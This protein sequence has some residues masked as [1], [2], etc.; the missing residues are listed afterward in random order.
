MPAT[1]TV[2]RLT[3]DDA[4]QVRE[5]AAA[6]RAHDGIEALG[7]QT[8]LRLR[9]ADDAVAHV[10]ATDDDGAVVGYAQLDTGGDVPSAELVVRP[11]RRRHGAGRALLD[12]VRARADRAA[13]WAHGDLPPARALAASA[14]L[15]VV[16]E[17]WQMALDLTA[18]PAPPREPEPPAGA[19]VRPF[20][21]GQD[22]AALLA[23]NARAFAWHPEQGRLGL[24]D[25]RLREAEPW[26]DPDDVVL[27][28]RDGALVAFCWLK[29][30]PG[31]AD[32]ELYVLGVDPDAQG[33]G[34]GRYLTAVTL[35]RLAA[36]GLARAVLY[37]E[38]TNHAAVRTYRAAGFERSRVDVQYG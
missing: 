18:L 10:L 31:S 35:A 37:T 33:Q 26:F 3:D 38:G 13:V 21:V 30:E 2:P 11:D 20:V 32:G 27:V 4:A 15:A 5:I 28:E 6:A 9:S 36:R 24:E 17:L 14:G 25:L 19:V 23:V 12:A 7:E 22:E 16:R 29:V 1:R 34:L 8:L